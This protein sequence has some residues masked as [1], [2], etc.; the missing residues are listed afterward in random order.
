VISQFNM[1]AINFSISQSEG[2]N[3]STDVTFFGALPNDANI[4]LFIRLFSATTNVTFA[5]D[6]TAFAPNTIKLSI[7]VVNWPFRSVQNSLAFILG[8]D[9][10]Q[11]TSKCNVDSG[12]DS[13]GNLQWF[14]ITLNSTSM[15]GKFMDTALLDNKTRTVT[16]SLNEDNSVT[17]SIPHF[18]EQAEIDPSYSVLLGERQD[19][20]GA[21]DNSIKS[22]VYIATFASLGGVIVLSAFAYFIVY[23]RLKLAI[24]VRRH[25]Q[26]DPEI[27]SSDHSSRWRKLKKRFK[28]VS[29]SSVELSEMPT[30]ER[31]NGMEAM[32]SAGHFKVDL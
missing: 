5:G 31:A 23:P 14:T 26:N 8:S 7:T 9:T 11:Q 18:W 24:Q 30:F 17:A 20:C 19:S 6:T 12:T 2:T 29:S 28:S 15:Y 32:T 27:D 21:N 1:S 3:V 10:K 22:V 25:L 4:T 13:S 16:F